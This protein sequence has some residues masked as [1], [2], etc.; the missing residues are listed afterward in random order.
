MSR[1]PSLGLEAIAQIAELWQIDAARSE[2]T[3][4]GFEWWPGRHQVS[5]SVRTSRESDIEDEWVIVV[6]TAFLKNVDHEKADVAWH[7]GEWAGVSPTYAWV[8]TPAELSKK[9]ER[10]VDQEVRFWTTAY[11]REENAHWLPKFIGR[12]ALLQAIDAQREADVAAQRLHAKPN[13]SG[14]GG[15][16]PDEHIDDMLDVRNAILIPEGRKPNRWHGITEFEQIAER[17]GRSD[18][19]YGNA[20][21]SGLTLE[22][23]IGTSSALIRLR[24]DVEHPRLGAGL[25]AS[26]E[27]PFERD[28][29]AVVHECRWFNFFESISWNHVPLLG[30]WHPRPSRI[31]G[32]F[33]AGHAFFIPNALYQP[34]LATNAALWQ[35][36][37]ARWAK[38]QFFA[39]LEDLTIGEVFERRYASIADP[40]RDD[41][42]EPTSEARL[43]ASDFPTTFFDDVADCERFLQTLKE[44]ARAEASG[45]VIA[46]LV[47]GSPDR[48]NFTIEAPNGKFIGDHLAP[49]VASEE[50][51]ATFNRG[52]ADM[53]QRLRAYLATNDL[54][55]VAQPPAPFAE[56]THRDALSPEWVQSDTFG[57]SR[58]FVD[59]A[60]LIQ[61]ES[62]LLAWVRYQLHPPGT[63]R[64]SN[65][66]VAEMWTCE[67]HDLEHTRFRMHRMLFTY[68][69]GSQGEPGRPVPEWKLATAGYL[70]TQAFLRE[71]LRWRSGSP[72]TST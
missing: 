7:L 26:L 41:L 43:E 64:F 23:P 31:E 46:K 37:R 59:R 57:E 8:Y 47:K 70:R 29:A 1:M 60:G 63:D 14:P 72:S 38:N 33:H 58:T 66:P 53:A 30:S 6:R 51:V 42:T 49:F 27:L 5:V 17:F 40:R 39:D 24:T 16:A 56:L 65:K 4:D 62:G 3:E 21:P 28:A 2:R 36:G 35:L 55:R 45:K 13:T 15:R 22:T 61:R 48:W 32:S 10:P 68:T 44:A 52:V 12:I 20:D 54:Q 50:N 9:Y 11:L 34:G 25:L 69:D 19:C 71:A 67:E 18:G